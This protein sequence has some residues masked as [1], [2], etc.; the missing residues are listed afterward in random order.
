MDFAKD[1][2]T[3]VRIGTIVLIAVH[4]NCVPS[5]DPCN[6]VRFKWELSEKEGSGSRFHENYSR[7]ILID[8]VIANWIMII[9]K[10]IL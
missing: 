2:N 3:E 9:M 5:E 6:R 4:E 1:G 10:T 7:T 8:Y